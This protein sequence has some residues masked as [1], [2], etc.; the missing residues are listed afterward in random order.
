VGASPWE[1][2]RPR[3]IAKHLPIIWSY[4][5]DAEN[6]EFVGRLAGEHIDRFFSHGIRGVPL[7]SVHSKENFPWIFGLFK[8]VVTTPALYRSAGCIF[9]HLDRVGLGER[10]VLP[11][12]SNGWKT[13]GVFGATEYRTA[14]GPLAQTDTARA[15]EQWF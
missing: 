8:K 13:D 4:K 10:I 2:I 12:A 15:N 6:D 14:P 9:A 3:A 7:A 5:Y 1:E 11:L